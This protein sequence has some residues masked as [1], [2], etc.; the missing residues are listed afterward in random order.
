MDTA[1]A[2]SPHAAGYLALRLPAG[3]WVRYTGDAA[4]RRLWRVQPCTCLAC[5]SATMHGAPASHYE[6]HAL[7][8]GAL[9][10]VHIEYTAV[11]PM[12]VPN[13]IY[14]RHTWLPPKVT[15][16]HLR[17]ELRRAFPGVRFSVRR[18]RG[19][20]SHDLT[21]R[22]SGGP[23]KAEVGVIVAPLLADYTNPTRRRARPVTVT[24]F[25]FTEQGTPVVDAIHLN[26]R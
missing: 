14:D 12:P 20:K 26:R 3:T 17:R 24:R 4:S 11:I 15:A 1:R 5:M 16:T 10:L 19:V 2:T 13:E 8:G 22:W 6:L 23:G 21:V 9:P 25:G 7:D 18:G